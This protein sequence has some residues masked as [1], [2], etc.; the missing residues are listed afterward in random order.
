M[1]LFL[2]VILFNPGDKK[3]DLQSPEQFFSHE[4]LL[5]KNKDDFELR[6]EQKKMAEIVFQAF[7]TEKHLFAEAGTGTGK[8]FAYLYPAILQ[9]LLEEKRV[10]ISTQTIALQEQIFLKDLPF[11]EEILNVR[12]RK[13]IAKGRG[14]YLC[15]RK[16]LV[17]LKQETK[18]EEEA[19]F[20]YKIRDWLPK[21]IKKSSSEGDREELN[22]NFK[23]RLYWSRIAS[24]SE[25]CFGSACSHYRDCFYFRQKRKIERS[26][27]IVT[28]HSLLI[29]DLKM[30]SKLL[31][32][33]DFLVIDEGH[34]FSDEFMNQYTEEIDFQKEFYFLQNLYRTGRSPLKKLERFFKDNIFYKDL[35]L[36]LENLQAILPALADSFKETGEILKNNNDSHY[37]ELRIKEDFFEKEYFIRIIDNLDLLLRGL[38]TIADEL[39]KISQ[40]L[41]EDD[42]YEE[43]FLEIKMI[44]QQIREKEILLTAFKN[45]DFSNFVYWQRKGSLLFAPLDVSDLINRNL[46]VLKKSV[47]V[48]SATLTVADKFDFITNSFGLDKE[49]LLFLK[50]QSPFD[51]KKQAKILILKEDFNFNEMAEYL[52]KISGDLQGGSLILFTNHDFLRKTYYSLL[53]RYPERIILADGISGS[54]RNI[55]ENF[56]KAHNPI[57]L[58]ADSYW[59]G[60]DLEKDYLKNVIMT[61][62]PFLP[63]KRPLVEASMER[64]TQRGG[65]NFYDYS[66]PKAVIRFRQGFGRLIR[67]KDDLGYFYILDNR[68]V[69]KSY[70][71]V[72]LASLPEMDKIL[73]RR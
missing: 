25:D 24:S 71:K 62:L 16:A 44:I 39:V 47:L 46:F 60:I 36:Y 13:A 2:E 9:A 48:T 40:T 7:S 73:L 52:T 43:T 11:L 28:N 8:S 35:S 70:G 17:R 68:V 69:D 65:N 22:L 41:E 31:P 15:L 4:G 72:F 61:K 20:N 49:D 5:K 57:L 29:R 27:L 54:R 18:D 58:G 37:Y 59:E 12:L 50:A 64:I 34:N 63:P 23:E 3:T 67:S 10:V 19:F 45:P 51:Y 26:L 1:G 56:R 66:L 55:I 53:E 14:N 32:D 33:Y 42:F 6:E 30:K 21:D 38:R